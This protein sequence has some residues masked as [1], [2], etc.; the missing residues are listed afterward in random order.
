MSDDDPAVIRAALREHGIEVT[1]RGRL[2]PEHI[3]AYQNLSGGGYDAGVTAGDFDDAPPGDD[4]DGPGPDMTE[5]TPRPGRGQ[6]GTRKT[7]ARARGR[8]MFRRARGAGKP[9][10]GAKKHKWVGTADVIEHFWSQL[11]WSARPIPPLQKIL[12]AQAP[13]AGV[14]LQ[15]ALRDTAIDR[16]ALQPAARLEDRLQAVNAM[17][18]PPAWVM[19]I[20]AFGG[21]VTDAEGNPVFDEDGNYVFDNRTQPLVG[22]LRF[23]LMSWLKIGGKKAAEIQASSEELIALGDEADELIRWILAPPDRGQSPRDAEKEA[24]R[25]GAA[26]V[27]AG[28]QREPGPPPAS[29][30]FAPAPTVGQA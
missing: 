11:A 28:Q 18:G 9:K 19:M 14:I 12:A 23:S 15:D 13:M 29:S 16:L 30:A 27:A 5:A 24:T 2:R 4:G 21:A 7:E 20:T 17:V 8:G 10:A 22:G 26:F 25:R 6:R 1:A 3:A